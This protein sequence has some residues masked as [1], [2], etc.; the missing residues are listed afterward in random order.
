MK[1]KRYGQTAT[2]LLE[3]WFVELQ[4]S[5]IKR[6]KWFGILT[7]NL[8]RYIIDALVQERKLESNFNERTNLHVNT[9]QLTL[10]FSA[11]G[12]ILFQLTKVEVT[13]EA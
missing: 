8:P 3:E 10:S 9:E 1:M 5:K 12:Q 11:N 2:M 6:S 7:V 4:A 13:N